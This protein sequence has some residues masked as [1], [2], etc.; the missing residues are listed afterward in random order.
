MKNTPKLILVG[1][2][3]AA[4]LFVS[5][6]S[7]P[8]NLRHVN[9][10]VTY[11]VQVG[12]SQVNA[13]GDNQNLNIV[14]NQ[15][16]EVIPGRTLF[17]NVDSPVIVHLEIYE[18]DGSSRRMIGQME[19]TMISSSFTPRSETAVFEFAAA[20]ANSSGTLQFTLSDEPLSTSRVSMVR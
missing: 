16:V 1:A 5:G 13:A 4:L 11:Q 14:A 20:H 17:F 2:I 6:C 19:G 8:S 9:Y 15:H 10:P 3:A 7:S 12:N 18:R